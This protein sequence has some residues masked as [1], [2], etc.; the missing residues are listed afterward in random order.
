MLFAILAALL[1]QDKNAGRPQHYLKSM[2]GIN[3]KGIELP[4]IVMDFPKLER[5]NNFFINVCILQL[6]KGKHIVPPVH[7]SHDTENKVHYV[8]LLHS[9]DYYF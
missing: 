1:L 4:M 9:Q 8:N 7:Y 3:V 2:H 5:Q 6:K